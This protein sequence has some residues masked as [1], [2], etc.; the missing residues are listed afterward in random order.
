M[1]KNKDNARPRS[2]PSNREL[3][4]S[5]LRRVLFSIARFVVSVYRRYFSLHI[6]AIIILLI[7]IVFMGDLLT[8]SGFLLVFGAIIYVLLY[9]LGVWL[10]NHEVE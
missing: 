5:K 7:I 8:K 10:E 2:S 1:N 4:G 9:H 3:L 6:W